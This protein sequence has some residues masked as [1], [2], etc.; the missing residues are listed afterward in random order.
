MNPNRGSSS[1]DANASEPCSAPKDT[2][3]LQTEKRVNGRSPFDHEDGQLVAGRYCLGEGMNLGMDTRHD[4]SPYASSVAGMKLK[5]D[6][7]ASNLFSHLA[8]HHPG[9]VPSGK[10]TDD[11]DHA[12]EMDSVNVQPMQQDVESSSAS[13]T[14]ESANW[15]VWPHM[16]EV[17][18]IGT[19]CF[20]LCHILVVR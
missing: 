17:F 19:L 12:M 7:S 20:V 9:M 8:F 13:A 11:G 6:F 15:K 10:V 2:A 4:L 5:D 18:L 3:M 16:E 1:N 14:G